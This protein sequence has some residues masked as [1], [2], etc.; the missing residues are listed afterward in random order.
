[1]ATDLLFLFPPAVVDS[2]DRDRIPTSKT[3]L[4]SMLSEDE[5]RNAILVVLANK[6]DMEGAMSVSEVYGALG[7]E[8]I[9]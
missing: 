3:E 4:I 8:G 1:M 6:Q 2:S 7:L 9:K 5:L